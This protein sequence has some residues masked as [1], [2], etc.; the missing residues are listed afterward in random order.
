M[1]AIQT[2]FAQA[3]VPSEYARAIN[4]IDKELAA[5]NA[6]RDDLTFRI[7]THRR[8]IEDDDMVMATW[9]TIH[10]E[11]RQE[12]DI[13]G[14]PHTS[15]IP[16]A[17]EPIC[18]LLVRKHNLTLKRSGISLTRCD[19]F[20]IYLNQHRNVQELKRS[21]PALEK[22]LD[23]VVGQIGKLEADRQKLMGG[24]NANSYVQAIT[25]RW[26]LDWNT[27][28]ITVNYDTRTKDFVGV[29]TENDFAFF[30]QGDVLFHA[31]F[32]REENGRPIFI[33]VMFG[34]TSDGKRKDEMIMLAVDG[35]KIDYQIANGDQFIL[36]RHPPF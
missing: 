7:E 30:N 34:R 22:D 25:G 2:A 3:P 1:F 9:R 35:D 18:D 20:R 32:D 10:A 33:G 14:V 8:A 5:L 36:Y 21:Q 28:V 13:R 4:Q 29:L 11:L 19:D 31:R 16:S 15:P 17:Y 6:K 26:Y 27:S 23:H 24:I 12:A